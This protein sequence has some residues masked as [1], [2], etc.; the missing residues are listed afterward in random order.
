MP[1]YGGI[2]REYYLL[3][4]QDHPELSLAEATAVLR[5]LG[6]E[7]MISYGE[8]GLIIFRAREDAIESRS[9]LLKLSFIKELGAVIRRTSP[10][11]LTQIYRE[12]SIA[13]RMLSGKCCGK[14]G[15]RI[16]NLGRKRVEL[17][18][19]TIVRLIRREIS[20]LSTSD[21]PCNPTGGT[22][23]LTIIIGNI[24][25]IA[26]PIA[27]RAS[28]EWGD[29]ARYMKDPEILF[30]S[31]IAAVLGN[32][33]GIVYDPFSGYGKIL[34]EIC[35][36]NRS[37]IVIGSDI[38]PEKAKYTKRSIEMSGA[39]CIFDAIVADALNP[40]LRSGCVEQVISDLPYGRR[41][42][43]VGENYL[44][45]PARFLKNIGRILSKES[46]IMISISLEQLR[47]IRSR[48]L[49]EKRYKILL[50]ASQHVH[51]SLTRVYLLLSMSRET[52][53]N[54][55]EK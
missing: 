13:A 16:Y 52:P 46:S 40:P 3:L 11:R 45:M 4:S 23:I 28:S 35:S 33:R 12:A 9:G 20:A 7:V 8:P 34:K 39:P 47:R 6:S 36:Y 50:L 42:R 49:N 10:S 37:S 22:C 2:Y 15:L 51:G 38:D 27:R 26:M 43:S 31:N 14:V 25:A 19:E 44:E 29:V 17:D 55:S 54:D 21:V 53:A 41:S 48:I 30:M 32:I 5:S 24:A 1:R 18:Y